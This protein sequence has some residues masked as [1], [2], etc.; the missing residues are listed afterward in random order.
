MISEG[1]KTLLLIGFSEAE[2]AQLEVLFQGVL[3]ERCERASATERAAK[4]T[5]ALVFL[6]GRDHSQ[7][8][9]TLA[10]EV[11]GVVNPPRPM[12]AAALASEDRSL[13]FELVKRGVSRLF[14]HPIDF[15]QLARQLSWMLRLEMPAVRLF[16]SDESSHQ[17]EVR[18]NQKL[19]EI[20]KVRARNLLEALITHTQNGALSQHQE[21]LRGE[22][23][24]CVGSLGSFGYVDCS[25]MMRKIENLLRQ[26][27]P[28]SPEQ[29]QELF[30]LVRATVEFL[31]APEIN[32]SLVPQAVSLPTVALSSRDEDLRTGVSTEALRC[33]IRVLD[34]RL[35]ELP[36]LLKSARPEGVVVDL[37]GLTPREHSALRVV[38]PGL[39]CPVVALA[40]NPSLEERVK[41]ASAGV[42]A[43]LEKP[44]DSGRLLEQ[45]QE[46]LTIPS[47]TRI[48]ALDDDPVFLAGLE[49]MLLPLKTQFTPLSDPE[50]LW[51]ALQT[52]NPDLV[53]LDINLLKL[54]GIKLCKALRNDLRFAEKTI[55]VMTST[56]D[57]ETRRRAYEAGADDCL[58][59]SLGT[60]EL[61]TRIATRLRRARDTR[62]TE[63]DE[64]TGVMTRAP[65][66]KAIRHLVNL[67]RRR[68]F[69]VSMAV[70]DLDKFKSINDTYGHPVGDEVLRHTAALLQESFRAEDVVSRWGGEEFVVAM[71]MMTREQAARRLEDVIARLR[72][73]EF[74]VGP[75]KFSVSFSAGVAQFPDDGLELEVLYKEADKALYH[76]KESGRA[77]V[78]TVSAVEASKETLSSLIDVV[79]VEDD[80]PLAEVVVASLE[81]LEYSVRWFS[82]GHEALAHLCGSNPAL[83][84]RVLLLDQDLP[85][86]TGLEILEK[87]SQNGVIKSSKVITVSGRMSEDQVVAGFEL[88]SVDHITKPFILPVLIRR[89][90]KA[91]SEID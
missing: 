12:F 70:I 3:V 68:L 29:N 77:R 54:D 45:L 79:L 35:E 15:K 27:Q 80:D 39:T 25:A 49:S 88:G 78:A 61:R 4:G 19:Q 7:E 21:E 82:D 69:P 58:S 47:F 8:V 84:A 87:L 56:L 91:L 67:G 81:S 33:G 72:Q 11:T 75:T 89:I 44:I 48:V 34:V 17:L 18:E 55:I 2:R 9:L 51:E 28:L 41:V 60:L 52:R 14:Y 73:H 6:D 65:A 57:A 10:S 40:R 53:I 46:L 43:L 66:I 5:Y 1:A 62:K 24:R 37:E 23:H 64:L 32:R 71:F 76:A 63:E 86:I 74:S 42:S 22:I 16:Q 31:L 26:E 30:R 83:R 85:D 36:N 20:V 50:E 38:L 13:V 90:E 59:K